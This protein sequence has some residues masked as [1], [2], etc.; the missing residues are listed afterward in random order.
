MSAITLPEPILQLVEGPLLDKNLMPLLAG[1]GKSSHMMLRLLLNI[2]PPGWLSNTGTLWQLVHSYLWLAIT[3]GPVTSTFHSSFLA[4]VQLMCG[5]DALLPRYMGV[6]AGDRLKVLAITQENLCKVATLWYYTV[7]SSRSVHVLPLISTQV[8]SAALLA[9]LAGGCEPLV[10]RHKTQM[11]QLKKMRKRSGNSSSSISDAEAAAS[12]SQRLAELELPSHDAVQACSEDSSLS[13][14]E[15]ENVSRAFEARM[16]EMLSAEHARSKNTTIT[17]ASS[18]SSSSRNNSKSSSSSSGY[19]SASSKD[20]SSS[21]INISS[22]AKVAYSFLQNPIA[23]LQIQSISISIT[24]PESIREIQPTLSA[25]AMGLVLESIVLLGFDVIRENPS[26]QGLGVLIGQAARASR[27][28]RRLLVASRGNLL[29]QV[30]WLA[31]LDRHEQ[32]QQH[33]P[34]SCVWS[35]AESIEVLCHFV[36]STIVPLQLRKE[37][38]YASSPP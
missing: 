14:T 2:K 9:Q 24:A 35:K 29:L 16:L 36:R 1:L 23:L 19:K 6:Y 11:K 25:A 17:T 15:Q 22:T 27:T 21:S 38:E 13:C 4:L 26:S 10:R 12:A 8:F 30:L 5:E 28:Q 7:G 37:G 20:G 33:Q 3:C 34:K 32:Q 18:S 31:A